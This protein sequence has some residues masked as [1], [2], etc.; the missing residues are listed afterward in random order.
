M[1]F[2]FLFFFNKVNLGFRKTKFSGG[3]LVEKFD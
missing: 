3:A 1:S 2:G